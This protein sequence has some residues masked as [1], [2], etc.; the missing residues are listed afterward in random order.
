MAQASRSTAERKDKR[1]A[2]RRRSRLQVR[3]WN[4]DFEACAFT[5]DVSDTGLLVESARRLEPG[6]RLHIELEL[7]PR[8]YLSEAVV[9]RRQDVPQYAQSFFKPAL[10]LRFLGLGEVM[11]EVPEPVVEAAPEPA[12]AAGAAGAA[13]SGSR[14]THAVDLRDPARLR[15]LFERDLSKGALL[16][17]TANPPAL[18]S[19]LCVV[20]RLPPPHADVIVKG[21]VV[22]SLQGHGQVG[23][24]LEDHAQLARHLRGVVDSLA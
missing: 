22:S 4:D 17:R 10:G 2:R 9:A 24:L 19:A 15:K 18:R 20:L 13:T 3:F 6:T 5:T 8:T 14:P 11:A 23:L 1:E 16:V 21:E 12:P 7:G